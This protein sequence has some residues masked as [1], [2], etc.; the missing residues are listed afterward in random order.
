MGKDLVWSEFKISNNSI[1]KCFMLMK[2]MYLHMLVGLCIF[3]VKNS[4]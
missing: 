4:T 3:A 2:A 1:H